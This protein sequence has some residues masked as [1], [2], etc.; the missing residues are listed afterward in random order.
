MDKITVSVYVKQGIS[1]ILIIRDGKLIQ[2]S[3]S[4]ITDEAILSSSYL[5]LLNTLAKAFRMV[6]NYIQENQ[7]CKNVVF[8]LNNS[9]IIKWFDKCYSK[10]DYQ[11]QFIE[12]V[13]LLQELPIK[14]LFSLS[15]KPM[16]C[17]YTDEKYIEKESV[18]GIDSLFEGEE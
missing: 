5:S 12:V 6:R 2:R 16:A 11:E 1:A 18:S 15:K 10:D 9:T 7:D 3:T 4:R 14:Y 13:N 17:V 8:E